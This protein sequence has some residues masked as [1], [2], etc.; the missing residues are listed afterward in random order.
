MVKG[1]S[2]FGIIASPLLPLTFLEIIPGIDLDADDEM[3]TL[4]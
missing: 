4:A 1:L 2:G 3:K